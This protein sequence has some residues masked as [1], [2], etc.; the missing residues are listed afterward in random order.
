MINLILLSYSSQYFS[1]I[2]ES[3]KYLKTSEVLLTGILEI[4]K[5]LIY[6]GI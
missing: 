1:N 3:I 2:N 4:V 6:L 5:K